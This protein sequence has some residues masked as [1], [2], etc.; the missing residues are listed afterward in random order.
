MTHFYR[1][2]AF[3]TVMM[4]SMGATV[5]AEGVV[6]VEIRGEPGSYQ[7]FRG[8][9]P[10]FIKG[11][12]GT[13]HLA[14]LRDQGA[15][16]IRTWHVGDG[17]ILDEAHALGMTVLLCLNVARE[18]H[19]FDYDD[20]AAVQRQLDELRQKVITHKDHPAL[21]AWMIGNELNM[22]Y[23]NPRVYDA[24]ND[25]A[26]MIHEVDPHHPVT[27]STAGLSPRV[28]RDIR[29]RAPE[30]DFLSVQL[31]GALADLPDILSR[32]DVRMPVM[33]TEWGTV[34]H[35]EVDTTDWGA[36]LELNSTAKAD[37]ILRGYQQ[38]IRPLTGQVIGDYMFLWGHK[39]ERT[40]TWY[41]VLMPG[42]KKTQAVDTLHY[43]WRG[44]WPS[45]RAPTVTSMTLAGKMATDS[46]RL[47]P[48]QQYRA[49]VVID[50]LDGEPINIQWSVRTE[51]TAT[52]SGGDKESIPPLIDV[53]L[54]TERHEGQDSVA[55]FTA[56]RQSGAYRLFVVG[57]DPQGNA[58]NENIP[59][60]VEQVE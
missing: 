44:H 39:Q 57:T 50:S 6:P 24:V 13:T 5:R 53:D 31:Y 2:A 35:W 48:G 56:P 41:G 21:L 8:G 34:G 14:L 43:L 52:Q 40:P 55:L 58:A 11:A 60:W 1:T 20:E 46:I 29:E 38:K 28:M 4:L 15:N 47:S 25:I 3:L 51:S 9:E 33:V 22:E 23:Q 45:D 37:N 19:G 59:F 27:T 49:R 30:L 26:R 16:S 54:K 10:Y 36:P 12:G 18:R 42:G 7:L 17:A 32:H